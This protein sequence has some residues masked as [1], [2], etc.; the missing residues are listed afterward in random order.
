MNVMTFQISDNFD[1]L[2]NS[3]FRLETKKTLNHSSAFL[4]VCDRNPWVTGAFAWQSTIIS[5]A[6]RHHISFLCARQVAATDADRSTHKHGIFDYSMNAHANFY[7]DSAS[8]DIRVK[9]ALDFEATPSYTLIIYA[10]D[11]YVTNIG[12]TEKR[13][14]GIHNVFM[15]MHLKNLYMYS[16]IC[17]YYSG[18]NV[19]VFPVDTWRN[20]NV[21]IT[22]NDVATSFWR[23]NHVVITSCVRW[24]IRAFSKE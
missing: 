1:S 9:S 16:K 22:S 17:L 24:V 7:L 12:Q 3:P 10:I 14:I 8:G 19:V 2:F 15:K 4:A 6:W 20:N 13:E 5:M 11:R 21:I 18:C 23:N